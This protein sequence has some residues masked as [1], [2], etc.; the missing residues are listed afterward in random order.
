MIRGGPW[1]V[2]V[3][4]VTLLV[5]A[6]P[7]LARRT[8][9]PGGSFVQRTPLLGLMPLGGN[10]DV[11]EIENKQVSIASGCPAKRAKIKAKKTET[12][13]RVTWK[14]CGTLRKVR[15]KAAITD[16]CRVLTGTL[17]VKGQAPVPVSATLT[18]CGDGI[19]YQ[20]SEA[21]DDGN[22]A[23]GDGCS[24]SCQLE[25]TTTTSLAGATTTTSTTPAPSTTTTST[26]PGALVTFV[27]SSPAAGE[28]GVAVTRET[29]V[30]FS[31]PLAPASVT[32]AAIHAAF[33]GETLPARLQVSTDRTFVTLFYEDILPGSARVRVT[34]D[35][36]QLR[37][38]AAR[39]VDADGNGAPG[40]TRTF[41]FETLNLTPVAG[42]SVCGRVFASQLAPTPGGGSVNEPLPGVTITVDGVPGLEAVT[43]EFGN[44][45][46]EPAPA[47][48]FFVH[49]DGRTATNGVPPGTYYPFV[50]KA[51]Q[52]IAGREVNVGEVY[53][54]LV[55]AGTLQPVSNTEETVIEFPPEVVE[56]HPEFE[57]V[58]ITV[59]AGSL[60]A[61]DGTRG[62]M[63]GIAPV[64]TDRMP[65]PPPLDLA[66][67]IVL[68]V[69][70][71]GP[72]NFDA[73][74]P[75]CFPNLP[76]PETGLPLPPGAESA[77]WSFNHDTGR[78]EMQGTMHVTADGRLVC[79]DPGVGVSA[80]GWHGSRP[81]A[82]G[83][84]GPITDGPP[85]PDHPDD[86][87]GPE[88]C[89]RAT[90]SPD[91][92][93][94]CEGSQC[95][96]NGTD[97]IYLHAGEFYEDVV[98]LR[99]KG[100]GF[101]FLW[102]RK[103]R[104]RLGANTAQGNGWDF[105]YNV[106]IDKDGAD[107]I[108]RDGNGRVDRYAAMPDGSWQ[109]REFFSTLQC[110]S[111]GSE[112]GFFCDDPDGGEPF[113]LRQVMPDGGYWE[114]H[115]FDGGAAEGK[116]RRSV[117]RNGNAM[118]FAYDAQGRLTTITDTLGRNIT[119]AYDATGHIASVTDFTGRQVRYTYYG[120]GEAGG[121]PGDLKTVTTP[122]VTGTPNGNDF[123]NGKTWTYTYSKGFADE[124]LNHNLLT[125]TDPKGQTYLRNTY[126]TTTDPAAVDFDKV[127]RQAWGNPD[128]TID[129]VY[130]PQVPSASNNQAIRKT[131]VRDRVG[132]V[133]ELFWDAYN[134]N[135]LMREFT[136][137]ADPTERT[138]DVLNRPTGKLRA[139]DPDFYE[140]RSTW[141]D[142]SLLVRQVQP[143]GTIDE[144]V[145]EQ[146][147][148]PDASLAHRGDVRVR[149]RLPGS[150]TPAGDQ[151]MLEEEYEYDPRFGGAAFMTKHVDARGHA[152]LYEYDARGNRTRITDR[153]VSVVTDLEYDQFG[154]RIAEVHPP[155]GSG[156]RRRDEYTYHAS[157]PQRG[158]QATRVVDVDGFDITT[159]WV[160]DAVGN[161]VGR[162]DARGHGAQL[163]RNQRDQIV[164]ELSREVSD[165]SGVRYRRD[166][167]YDANDNLIRVDIQNVDE[168]GAVVAANP[169]L[170]TEIAHD[171]LNHETRT[172][173]EV[174]PGHV[175]A[176][177]TEYDANRNRTLARSGEATAGRQPSNLVQTLYDERNLPFRVIRAPGD[178]AQSS[179]QLD[180]DGNRNL[181][182]A[183]HGLEDPV[184]PRITV[185][186]YD[187]YDRPVVT[188]DPMGNVTRT[189]YD[190]NGNTLESVVE[191][192]L[193]DV[194]GGTG[195]VRLAATTGTF[196]DM[197]RATRTD[198]AFFDPVTQ[199]DVG[200]G[201]S[202]VVVEWSGDSQVVS[203]TN[204]NGHAI[205]TS[206]DTANRRATLLDAAG[207]TVEYA[208]DE[209]SNVVGIT[210]VEKSDLGGDDV[211]FVTVATY[212]NLDRPIM[213]VDSGG[214]VSRSG[215]DS[216]SNLVRSQ[217]GRANI[218]RTTF[219]GVDRPIE[220][221]RVLTDTGDGSGTEIG[222]LR[223][224]TAYD[225]NWRVVSMTDDRGNATTHAYDP[226]DRRLA[227]EMADGTREERTFD[228]HDNTLTRT[229]PNGTVQTATYDRNDRLVEL[230]VA[231]GAGVSTDTTMMSFV[232]DGESR[233]VTAADDDSVVTRQYDSLDHVV[234]E[235]LDGDLTERTFDGEG[236][237]LSLTYPGGR[238]ITRTYDVLERV[239]QIQDGGD[240]LAAYDY[241]GPARTARRMLGNGT[242]LVFEYDTARRIVRTTHAAADTTVLDDRSYHW[243]AAYRKT[244]VTDEVR[245]HVV[246][247]A[248][249]SIYRVRQTVRTPASGPATTQ[250]YTLDGAGNRTLV[251]GGAAA[252]SYTLDATTPVPADDQ[253]NQY[254]T[255]GFDARTYDDDGNLTEADPTSGATRTLTYD[256]A[257]QMVSYEDG[258]DTA[259]YRYD[260]LGRRI[261]KTVDGTETRFFFDG[262][263]EIEEQSAVGATQATYVY[264]VFVDEPLAMARGA[265]SVWYHT[266]DLFSVTALTDGTG[267]LVETYEFDDFGQPTI[268][269]PGGGLRA[270]SAFDN[271]YLFTGRRFD[272]ESGLYH[273]R[274]RY[275]DPRAGR[276]TTRDPMGGFGDEA[277]L[278]NAYTYVGND[279]FTM[280]DPMGLFGVPGWILDASENAARMYHQ[281]FDNVDWQAFR[282][283]SAQQ[284][285]AGFL[286]GLDAVTPDALFVWDKSGDP[287]MQE[288]NVYN[289][290]IAL[291]FSKRTVS[292]V[293]F[294][295]VGGESLKATERAVE[296]QIGNSAREAEQARELIEDLKAAKMQVLEEFTKRTSAKT[297]QILGDME[298]RFR[299]SEHLRDAPIAKQAQAMWRVMKGRVPAG[300]ETTAL[301][302]F[303]S[304]AAPA[305]RKME[306]WKGQQMKNL[307]NLQAAAT[308]RLYNAER[309]LK[310]GGEQLGRVRAMGRG[311]VKAAKV[312][313]PVT[314]TYDLAKCIKDCEEDPCPKKH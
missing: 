27:T 165:G 167:F 80:P 281:S 1:L 243:D 256:A 145:Y 49:I 117:D 276:F 313:A 209:N 29:I 139:S 174:A 96:K 45:R 186:Q 47:G 17:K 261:A 89:P 153:I 82:S 62:G 239:A 115:P 54:P 144:W 189:T 226:L 254:T 151:E 60:Y 253:T 271:P 297:A 305:Y 156:H 147:L 242:S 180:Y 285:V 23:D 124:R 5:P 8:P 133:S 155:N 152:T 21:C 69:Q 57:G 95:D 114:Y 4:L 207:N 278:G 187:G 204:D 87:K 3:L 266:D 194:P 312:A 182:R 93:P 294:G 75:I 22:T 16:E 219:D 181:V 146:D 296:Q 41:D 291:C 66:F 126:A 179:V 213:L 275:L 56:D 218:V 301:E 217:D 202:S 171:I 191:G 36:G 86:P 113:P 168:T 302:K 131:I 32:P 24:A 169:Q 31:G 79:T 134:R 58:R 81:G 201:Q 270:T 250:A 135:V 236:N 230:D 40:G 314:Y 63:V 72:T 311:L 225:D 298:E 295:L 148:N 77:L 237:V 74:A 34:I 37:D 90:P 61:D 265:T 10:P 125:V 122:A 158:Y 50:G 94:K 38:A 248:R 232:Y 244:R 26:L 91:P 128:E 83:G 30:R 112:C 98:D 260:A 262:D 208:Y 14:R 247:V 88:D 140:T 177:E 166:Y 304:K 9:C 121:S 109:R 306:A 269:A 303:L 137:R 132:N 172:E 251:V 141:N 300:T 13:V 111:G 188:T 241:V 222:T 197:D 284:T 203:T 274:A 123:P 154:Q 216:R 71:N 196:D 143:N 175:I 293:T 231:P 105:S 268:R 59:P 238:T 150:H 78:F 28:G 259:T 215:Y 282:E 214:N 224:T 211:S 136:G 178:P 272:P 279:P 20:P 235:S 299:S 25:P 164:R 70:T 127:V 162:T 198:M 55:G 92:C 110:E 292:Q 2:S 12:R 246:D 76:L 308:K 264:G 289:K 64:P 307:Q 138:T 84:G 46:L 35:G 205:T 206:F 267:A 100:R 97:P 130:V 43:D 44:F 53:L 42:T 15:L 6:A 193:L 170:T 220:V 104:S 108:Q 120:A 290:C 119:V 288:M 160:Y 173:Q 51:W 287:R 11:V 234:A 73:V 212:D 192:E 257:D 184:A 277:N 65:G 252:G 7:S 183:A 210:E 106:S 142:D 227:T 309:M 101:D 39:P 185:T 68:T 221:T 233:L 310:V 245:N 67:P 99:I 286:G 52:S 240:V 157:G 200:D 33:G 159:T 163:V 176:I 273:Y 223:T 283:G 228:V 199:I 48:L 103:Y 116:L 280:L 249:D 229:D 18:A 149:R 263:Q 258:D 190:E 102:A 255:T 85:R 129:L 118:S 107:L 195:N 161:V 19:T